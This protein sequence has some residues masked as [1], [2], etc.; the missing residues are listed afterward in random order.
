M[1]WP[2]Q[3][4]SSTTEMASFA[5]NIIAETMRYKHLIDKWVVR[6]SYPILADP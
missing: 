2:P 6:P 1:V 3:N 5:A 4:I